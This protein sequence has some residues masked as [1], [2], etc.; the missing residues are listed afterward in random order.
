MG[1]YAKHI[2]P[3]IVELSLSTRVVGE[4]RRIA[5]KEAAGKT[6]EIGFGTGLNLACYPESVTEL[7]ALDNERMLP[8]RVA[9]RIAEAKMPVEQ[10]TLDASDRLPFDDESFD[11][12]VTT[13]TLCS[14]DDVRAALV[15]MRRVL[16]RS[17]K[18]LFLEHGRSDSA[19]V[20]KWQDRLNPIQKV[21]GRG[22]NMNRAIDEVVSGSGFRIDRLERFV[23]RDTPRLFGSM[24]RGSATR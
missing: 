24:Y 4:E 9:A 14:I 12:V 7:V 23:M 18:F 16:N 5:L 22:C 13:F 8:G 2:F 11:T 1:I 17:G 15:E 6:L 10:V 3:R 20:S 21:V 19:S